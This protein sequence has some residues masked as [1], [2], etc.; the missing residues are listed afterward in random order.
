MFCHL[1]ITHCFYEVS[2]HYNAIKRRKIKQVIPGA[3]MGI[4]PGPLVPKFNML[5]TRP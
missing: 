4:N 3:N 2:Q 5:T 1:Y